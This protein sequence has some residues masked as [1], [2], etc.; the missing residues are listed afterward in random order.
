MLDSKYRLEKINISNVEDALKICDEYLGIGMHTKE[1]LLNDVQ[2]DDIYNYIVYD[3]DKAA[4][5]FFCS[6]VRA[7]KAADTITN[8][9]LN[10]CD[11]EE[12]IGICNSIAI[13]KVYRE[14]GLAYMLLRYFCNLLN[15]SQKINKIFALAWIIR[16]Y[17]PAE[18]ILTQCGF[19]KLLHIKS[20]W[21][22]KSGLYCP[23]CCKQECECDGML[24]RKTLR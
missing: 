1:S 19:E 5:I 14:T 10:F 6:I 13:T 22:E 11:S 17:I 16:K 24:Y 4:G 18:K 9:I 7:K 15:Q 23:I 20:P 3:S 8:K 12:V 2:S 21:K